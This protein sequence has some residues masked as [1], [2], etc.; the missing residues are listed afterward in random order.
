[1]RQGQYSYVSM[2][3]A[4]IVVAILCC[5][6]VPSLHAQ[7]ICRQSSVVC[8]ENRRLTTDDQRASFQRAVVHNGKWLTAASV[9]ALIV[10]AQ[11]EHSQSRREWSEDDQ[12]S[13]ACCCE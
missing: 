13:D 2:M 5:G 9:A 10:F 3:R 6:L 4:M 8:T 11:R 7:A 12:G 1:R